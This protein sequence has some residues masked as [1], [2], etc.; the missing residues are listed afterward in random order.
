MMLSNA[1]VH[2]HVTM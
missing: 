1:N 2:R